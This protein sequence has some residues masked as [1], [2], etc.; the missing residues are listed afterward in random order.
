MDEEVHPEV[1]D[2]KERPCHAA[3]FI[4]PSNIREKYSYDF[5]RKRR[6]YKGRVD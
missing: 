5:I 6:R 1:L 3:L 4:S 2:A